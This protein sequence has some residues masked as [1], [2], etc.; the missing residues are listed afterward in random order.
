MNGAG[1]GSSTWTI[2]AFS[3]ESDLGIPEV[4]GGEANSDFSEEELRQ[5]DEFGE[6]LTDEEMDAMMSRLDFKM[7]ENPERTIS[8]S[9]DGEYVYTLPDGIAYQINVPVGAVTSETVTLTPGDGQ[10][11]LEILKDGEP[12]YRMDDYTF[13]ETGSYALKLM[14][15]SGKMSGNNVSVYQDT[16]TFTICTEATADQDVITVPEGFTLVSLECDG[17]PVPVS[18]T[19]LALEN[20]GWYDITFRAEKDPSV[21]WK[22]GYRLDRE[23]PVLNF[24]KDITK[25]IVK[26][27]ISMMPSE[28]GC[29]VTVLHG[30]ERTQWDPAELVLSESG[31]YL[32][33]VTDPA[34]NYTHYTINVGM[35]APEFHILWV[36]IPAVL[37]AG[38][39]LYLKHLRGHMEVL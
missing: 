38:L 6:N 19:M 20:D 15:T 21:T 17:E 2:P 34:G 39:A 31:A 13:S 33:T 36:I 30:V 26:P 7:D 23:V 27:P 1:D 10:S 28:E 24:S 4:T 14:S 29:V 32:L 5:L 22:T 11:V 35:K 18:R 9:P 8:Q 25:G 3:D 12:M 16:V 37:I